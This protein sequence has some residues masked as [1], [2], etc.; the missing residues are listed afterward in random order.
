MI[1]VIINY[2][3]RAIIFTVQKESS[4]TSFLKNYPSFFTAKNVSP[5]SEALSKRLKHVIHFR[6]SEGRDISILYKIK[7]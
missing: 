5:P 4:N 2:S 7:T 3:Q 1:F 6:N